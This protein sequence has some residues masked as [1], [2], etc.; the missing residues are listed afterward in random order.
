MF[1]PKSTE[2]TS[3]DFN[4]SPA[5]Q[6]PDRQHSCPWGWGCWV[7]RWPPGARAQPDG[8]GISREPLGLSRSVISGAQGSDGLP[9][10]AAAGLALHTQSPEWGCGG[11]GARTYSRRWEPGVLG[12]TCHSARHSR[13]RRP[14]RLPGLRCP[15]AARG[16]SLAERG[17]KIKRS[18][19]RGTGP[20][21]SRPAKKL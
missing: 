1:R 10:L 8:H 9:L 12:C 5:L 13:S 21:S 6:V 2:W 14:A 7:R 15:T 16:S 17:T 19:L 18:V 20:A 3:C 4:P 11:S